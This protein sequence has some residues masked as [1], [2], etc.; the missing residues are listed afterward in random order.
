MY[1]GQHR[2]S[3]AKILVVVVDLRESQNEIA[4]ILR[5]FGVTDERCRVG[6]SSGPKAVP[7]SA[8]VV[9]P[10]RLPA[11]GSRRAQRSGASARELRIRAE[12]LDELEHARKIRLGRIGVQ[13]DGRKPLRRKGRATP[14]EG[15]ALLSERLKSGSRCRHVARLCSRR[16][17]WGDRA[18]PLLPRRAALPGCLTARAGIG[19]SAIDPYSQVLAA[20]PVAPRPF[21]RAPKS[22]SA[23]TDALAAAVLLIQHSSGYT[24]GVLL[25]KNGNAGI[26]CHRRKVPRCRKIGLGLHPTQ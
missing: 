26:I 1:I 25:V 10:E 12:L 7:N 18:R 5:H 8:R 17:A 15:R 14:A 11:C 22:W 21:S 23:A 3:D 2:V 16:L 20:E 24:V 6:T 19:S 4:E 13:R 9:I